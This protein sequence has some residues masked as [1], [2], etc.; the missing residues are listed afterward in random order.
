MGKGANE[1]NPNA[2]PGEENTDP[3]AGE[4]P[5]EKKKIPESK[6]PTVA[7]LQEKIRK[8]EAQGEARDLL[9]KAGIDATQPLVEALAML[10]DTDARKKLIEGLPKGNSL[11]PRST[12]P[13]STTLKESKVPDGS[14]PEK[15]AAYWGGKTS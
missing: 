3:A 8:M 11:A 12:A 1:E 9:G 6:E 10:P 4:K 13:R 5:S 2:K 15:I 7:E 14:D